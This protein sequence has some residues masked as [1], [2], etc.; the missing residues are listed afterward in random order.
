M[1]KKKKQKEFN[2]DDP[3]D[4]AD[5][6]QQVKDEQRLYYKALYRILN[7][8]EGVIVFS[9]ILEDCKLFN[10]TF[11]G[12]VQTYFNEGN[13]NAGLKI[14][15]DCIEAAPDKI[16]ELVIKTVKGDES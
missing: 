7:M 6:E 14:F 1:K 5:L 11:T 12:N 10:T 8:R 3:K 16:Q 4:V 13:R 9:K 2:A 15:A